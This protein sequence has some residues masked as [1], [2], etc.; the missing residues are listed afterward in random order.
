[1]TPWVKV[2]KYAGILDTRDLYVILCYYFILQ[3]TFYTNDYI[4]IKCKTVLSE[5]HD[6]TLSK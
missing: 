2:H 4:C 1:M 3:Q 6:L 5:K